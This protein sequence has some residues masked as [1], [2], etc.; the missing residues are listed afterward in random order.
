MENVLAVVSAKNKECI[1]Y[2][3]DNPNEIPPMD[4]LLDSEKTKKK[5]FS[6]LF[7]G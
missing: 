5:G 4:V 1:Q 6:R 2:Y 3:L 7:K